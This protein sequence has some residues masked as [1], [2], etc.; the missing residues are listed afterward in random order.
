[1]V[2]LSG[3]VSDESSEG[4]GGASVHIY[5]ASSGTLLGELTTDSDGEWALP[6]F[7]DQAEAQ[8]NFP[9]RF[10]VGSTDYAATESH[11][12]FS[13]LDDAWPAVPISMGPGQQISLGDQGTAGVVLSGSDATANVSGGVYDVVTGQG[14]QGVE[15]RMRS[16]WNAPLDQEILATTTSGIDGAFSMSTPVPGTYTVEAIADTGYARTVSPLQVSD[17]ASGEQV[18]LMSPLV[19]PGQVRVALVWD[20]SARDLDLHVSGPKSGNAGRYQVYVEDTPHPVNGDPIAAVEFSGSQWES[21]GVYTLRTGVY[22]FS[23]FDRDFGIRTES[24]AL[25]GLAPTILVWTENTSMMESLTP[26][27]IGTI[28]RA[29]EFHSDSDAFFRLQQMDEGREDSDLSA[30]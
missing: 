10:E 26:G 11:W 4:I 5:N 2:R 21:I 25:S 20:D 14:L 7:V 16:G 19:G 23:A 29:V 24:Q 1:V 8:Q 15:L 12:T 22:R 13:W 27:P 3:F 17:E 28:W 30:F 9:L 6:L 18:L